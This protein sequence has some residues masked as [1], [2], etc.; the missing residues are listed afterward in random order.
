MISRRAKTIMNCIGR[1]FAGGKD[2]FDKSKVKCYNCNGFGHF[3]RECQRPKVNQGSTPV[4]QNYSYQ[5]SSSQPVGNN[6]SSRA[7]VVTR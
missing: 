2:G 4:R 1:K 5:G 7:L 6:V 3:A